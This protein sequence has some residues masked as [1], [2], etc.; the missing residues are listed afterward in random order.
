MC[1]LFKLWAKNTDVTLT[2]GNISEENMLKILGHFF[3]TVEIIEN[4]YILNIYCLL[5]DKIKDIDQSFEYIK[6]QIKK[7]CKLALISFDEA[8]NYYY[9][10]CNM[11]SYKFIV[12]KRY[13]EKYLYLKLSEHIVYEKF[14]ETSWIV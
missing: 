9:K 4:K 11:N 1:S 3:P 14:I 5:W 12:S 6:N 10:Y 7:E 2:N 8:Y 13:F